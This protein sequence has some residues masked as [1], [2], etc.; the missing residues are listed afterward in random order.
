MDSNAT[1]QPG[2]A[3]AGATAATDTPASFPSSPH[4]H[5][6]QQQQ[7]PTTPRNLTDVPPVGVVICNDGVKL[8]YERFGSHGPVVVLIHGW[9]GS[10]HYYDLN[11]RLI[12]RTCQVI[13]FDLRHHGES[14]KPPF[15]FH[16]ARLAADLRNILIALDLKDVTA[17]GSSMGAAILWSYFEL[18]GASRISGAVFVDQAP[19]Q[20]IAADWKAGSTGCYDIA[21]LTKLQCRLLSD[22]PAFARDN[23]IFCS[24]AGVPEDALRVLESETLKANPGALAALMADHT[25]LDWR[26]VLRRISVPCVN[27]VG[28]RSAVFPWWGVEEVGRLVPT[29]HTYY[30]EEEN[31]WLYLQQ[32]AKFSALVAAFASEGL[33][34]A[35]RV[36]TQ[37]HP[38]EIS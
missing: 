37:L 21:T 26:P 12:A 18:F 14:D 2:T 11:V 36:W 28:R 10:R 25:A 19:L 32:P 4:H 29:C 35:D 34:G 31:H 5:H 17:V 7:P 33:K 13:T 20:N 8:Q 1:S 15:G 22:F 3:T 16:V 6:H 23:A 9:S 30:F 38:L 24:G 27:V